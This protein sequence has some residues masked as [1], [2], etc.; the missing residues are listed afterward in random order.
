[1]CVVDPDREAT[2][3]AGDSGG[4]LFVGSEGNLKQVG[5]VS[6]GPGDPKEKEYNMFVNLYH[7]NDWVTAAMEQAEEESWLELHTGANHGVVQIHDKSGHKTSICR[8]NVGKDEV[9]AICREQGYKMGVLVD[10]KDYR[11][12]RKR[13]NKDEDTTPFGQTN[14]KCSPDAVD[15][16]AECTMDKYEESVVP[17]FSGEELAVKCANQVWHFQITRIVPPTKTVKGTSFVKGK[18]ICEVTARKYG[19]DLDLKSHVRVGLVIRGNDGV[20]V[21]EADMKYKRRGNA[22]MAKVKSTDELK[23]DEC[24]ACIAYVRGTSI[25]TVATHGPDDCPDIDQHY[26]QWVKEQSEQQ[27][28]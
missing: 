4:P 1:M 18:A 28:D 17:C 16:M 23:E 5:I 20:E 12:D 21:V 6:W 19:M 13:G 8:D 14:L 11:S 3:F 15:V 27:S 7:Y 25:H 2:A 26:S 22:Y 24:F 9:N 10:V